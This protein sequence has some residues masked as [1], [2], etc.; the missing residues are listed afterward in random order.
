[1]VLCASYKRGTSGSEMLNNLPKDTLLVSS[2]D[3]DLSFGFQ[4]CVV[5][6]NAPPQ[7]WRCAT[8]I[9]ATQD[10]FFSLQLQQR[11]AKLQDVTVMISEW[12]Q[13]KRSTKSQ[14]THDPGVY[15]HLPPQN[16]VKLSISFKYS[17]ISIWK[18]IIFK[19]HFF[20]Q[21]VI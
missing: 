20:N 2:K 17:L 12:L 3:S 7:R 13:T 9:D 18:L 11:Q 5:S 10:Y 8:L 1:M 14:Q 16:Y 4:S 15:S 21:E 6:I 19:F